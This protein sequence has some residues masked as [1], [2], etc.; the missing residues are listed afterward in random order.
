MWSNRK[1]IIARVAAA[2]TASETSN[3]W[4][5][6]PL[7]PEYVLPCDADAV[8][9]FKPAREEKRLHLELLPEPFIGAIEAPVVLLALNPG[10]ST[11]DVA[12]HGSA[13]F[14]DRVRGNHARKA[15]QYPFYYLDPICS[16]TPGGVWWEKK[17]RSLRSEGFDQ[18]Q[19]ASS[20]LCVQYFPYHSD[21]YAPLA[22]PSQEYSFML[23]RSAIGR[24]AVIVIMRAG[25]SWFKRVPELKGYSRLQKLCNPR[26]VTISPGN[27]PGYNDIVSAIQSGITL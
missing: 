11:E 1:R 6:L 13:D 17:F 7:E 21:Q 14:R 9:K 8:K 4:P 24:G 23:V 25:E 20:I 27:C 18:Q 26:N 5:A 15:A 3:P 12:V 19:V 10:F 2:M 22:V 16:K